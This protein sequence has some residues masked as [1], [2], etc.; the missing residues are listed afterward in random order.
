MDGWVGGRAAQVLL[1]TVKLTLGHLIDPASW[2]AKSRNISELP[3][4]NTKYIIV[5]Q[6]VPRRPAT[7]HV[8]LLIESSYLS[9]QNPSC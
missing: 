1:I 2:D 7:V 6:S 5:M 4:P 9:S 3:E 8:C